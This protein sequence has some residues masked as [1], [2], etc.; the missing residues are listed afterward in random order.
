MPIKYGKDSN[1]KAKKGRSGRQ[2]LSEEYFKEVKKRTYKE[3]LA[4]LLPDT[5]LA[6][7]H[8]ELLTVPIK[9]RTYIKGD[10]KEEITALDTNA[11][12]SGLDMAYKLKGEYAGDKVIHSGS[13]KQ[14]YSEDTKN[15]KEVL[16][17]TN[18]YEER[19]RKQILE[20]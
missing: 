10:F 3:I 2:K 11:V 17:I 15:L 16:D 20:G 18:E 13:I 8:L 19:I 1:F 4:E 12:K 6:K 7:K 14:V 9:T 5:L